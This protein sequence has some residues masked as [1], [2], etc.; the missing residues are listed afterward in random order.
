[1]MKRCKN[2]SEDMEE[3]LTGSGLCDDCAAEAEM[4][5]DLLDEDAT[6]T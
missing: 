3:D 1:M 2:C 5:D 4:A 6:E